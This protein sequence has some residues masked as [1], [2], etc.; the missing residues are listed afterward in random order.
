MNYFSGFKKR[1]V[2]LFCKLIFC[3]LLLFTGRPACAQSVRVVSGYVLNAA[4][5][6]PLAAATVRIQNKPYGTSTDSQGFFTL[7]AGSA[8]PAEDVL[9]VTAVGFATRHIKLNRTINPEQ[10]IMLVPTSYVLQEITITTDKGSSRKSTAEKMVK[11]ALGNMKKACPPF[12]ATGRYEHF[13]LENNT[14]TKLTE[15]QIVIHDPRGYGKRLAPEY[16]NESIVFVQK[17]ESLDHSVDKLDYR[18]GYY[19]LYFNPFGFLLYNGLKYAFGSDEYRYTLQ[20]TIRKDGRLYYLIKAKDIKPPEPGES[21]FK[22]KF[23]MTFQLTEH[24]GK[25]VVSR[26]ELNYQT[27]TDYDQFEQTDNHNFT[28]Y[29]QPEGQYYR[30]ARIECFVVQKDKWQH[31]S[32]HDGQILTYH[33]IDFN[34]V[35][36]NAKD[37]RSV[38]AGN[39]VYN[40]DYWQDKPLNRQMKKDL[41]KVVPLSQQFARQADR[42]QFS[43][44]QD[45]LTWLIAQQE[46]A[47]ALKQHHVY[48]IIWDSWQDL[49]G[50]LD[51][52]KLLS[53]K[54]IDIIF[55]GKFNSSAEWEFMVTNAEFMYFRHYRLPYRADKLVD[56]PADHKFV[57]INKHDGSLKSSATPFGQEVLQEYESQ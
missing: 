27:R 6:T 31:F 29:L 33:K 51:F 10:R 23:D 52:E 36:F 3:T 39:R 40:Q 35:D 56:K 54:N 14:F 11:A 15:G 20:D 2:A 24:N 4:D 12:K 38:K 7:V 44:L 18:K 45:S 47:N 41:S 34:K 28:L 8:T 42:Q 17:R 5:S 26:F 25:L 37:I 43:R 9:V 55:I 22:E 49:T 48:L 46:I 32:K 50:F 21:H 30:P 1:P 16:L 19:S 57:L 13:I 53:Y